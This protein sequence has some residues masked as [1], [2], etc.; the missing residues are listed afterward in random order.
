MLRIK[1][2]VRYSSLKFH[3]LVV[4]D[5]MALPLNN[6]TDLFD[7]GQQLAEVLLCVGAPCG[8]G[9]DLQ[10]AQAALELVDGLAEG[11]LVPHLLYGVYVAH[12][13]LGQVLA[14]LQHGAVATRLLRVAANGG[15]EQLRAFQHHLACHS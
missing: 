4:S 12:A 7:R 8:G 2:S 5:F 11:K 13:V 10:L 6:V 9:A 14:G 15:A 1:V 3:I